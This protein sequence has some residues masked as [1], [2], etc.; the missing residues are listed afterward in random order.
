MAPYSKSETLQ[1]SKSHTLCLIL[2]T[3]D[4]LEEVCHRRSYK[5]LRLDGQTPTAKRQHLVETFNSPYS[6]HC[7][8]Q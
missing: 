1:R 2:Q 6:Q 8:C 3:L 4:V 7:E 5:Y